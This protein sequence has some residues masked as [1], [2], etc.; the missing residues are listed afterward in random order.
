MRDTTE[1][2]DPNSY[3]AKL[4]RFW[5]KPPMETAPGKDL[6]EQFA[7]MPCYTTLDRFYRERL[8]WCGGGTMICYGPTSTHPFSDAAPFL[9]RGLSQP[10]T[11][12]AIDIALREPWETIACALALVATCLEV[13]PLFVMDDFPDALQALRLKAS[14]GS[15]IG[16][17]D[18]WRWF[19]NS[20][21]KAAESFGAESLRGI[22][23]AALPLQPWQELLPL[24][25]AM[26]DPDPFASCGLTRAAIDAEAQK[27]ATC[28]VLPLFSGRF[29]S[30]EATY[31]FWHCLPKDPTWIYRPC[32]VVHRGPG[33]AP[34]IE[35]HA[36]EAGATAADH[37]RFIMRREALQRR[38]RFAELPS[39]L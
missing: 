6:L 31:W 28:G 37:Q 20:I 19:I 23:R 25:V 12:W 27:S 34:V 3:Q 36:S 38:D 7:R 24:P 17:E 13:Q 33:A 4:E 15:L 30:E 10:F 1:P 5:G 39:R 8:R 21:D 9:R 16:A 2:L 22:L 11:D 26:P 29:A 18:E 35:H 14:M 32:V